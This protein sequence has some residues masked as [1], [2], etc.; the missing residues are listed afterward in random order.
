MEDFM[1]NYQFDFSKSKLGEENSITDLSNTEK[2]MQI[3]ITFFI[4]PL[5]HLHNE[6]GI[7]KIGWLTYAR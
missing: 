1:D 6:I 5:L 3:T 2:V 7:R 4:V